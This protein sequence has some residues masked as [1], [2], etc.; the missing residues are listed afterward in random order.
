MKFKFDHTRP[1]LSLLLWA[2]L[3]LTACSTHQPAA[4]HIPP[5]EPSITR[6]YTPQDLSNPRKAIFSHALQSIGTPYAWGGH[7]PARGFDCSGLVYYTHGSAGIQVPRTTSA[8]FKNGRPVPKE[9]LV[10]GDLVFFSSP[11][12]KAGLH[13]GIFI[14][15]GKFVHAPGRGKTVQIAF[16]DN[17][18]FKDHFLGARSY[19]EPR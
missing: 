17:V 5:K 3:F 1:I 13:V 11:K 9:S 15:N 16:L 6:G 10:P 2:T 7:D 12:K 4:T 19:I 8:L 18:Y 14:G